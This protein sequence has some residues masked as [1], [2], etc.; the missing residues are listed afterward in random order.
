MG[1]SFFQVKYRV[2]DYPVKEQYTHILR[3]IQQTGPLDLPRDGFEQVNSHVDGDFAFIHDA[4][5][6]RYMYYKNCNFTEVGEAFAEQPVAV[7][8]Q[9]VHISFVPPPGIPCV[10]FF[11]P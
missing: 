7:A 3:V 5:E 4:S 2:W 1:L 10:A 8:V 6:V 11:L 9:Q